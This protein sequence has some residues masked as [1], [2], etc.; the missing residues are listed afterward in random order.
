MIGLLA[1]SLTLGLRHGIDWD[2]I[3]AIAD[4]TSTAE[5]RRRGW[6][7]SLF[8]ALG[9]AAVVFLLGVLVIAFSTTL[10][11][12]T[13]EWLGRV[14]GFTLVAL[15]VWVL[16]ELGRKGEDFRLRSRWMLVLSGTFAGLRRVRTARSGRTIGVDHQHDHDHPKDDAASHTATHAHD[17]SHLD[18]EAP[19][20]VVE[21]VGSGMTL[22]PA[23]GQRRRWFDAGHSP[24]SSH[25]H[26][27]H[28]AIALPDDP[29]SRYEGRTAAGIGMLHGVGIESPTQIALFVVASRIGGLTNGLLLLAAWCVGLVVANIG[30]A[31]LAGLGLLSA[32]R[33]FR[34]YAF[35]AILVAVG[36]I[37]MGLAMIGGFEFL[38][39]LNV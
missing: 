5:T 36:S 13:A 26:R 10:P 9:H 25:A 11:E 4:L 18:V 15:G 20:D 24:T 37:A 21:P 29:F 22:N 7:L 39:E 28:H 34:L 8:Y 16:I 14:V 33:N 17:H 2:H 6:L 32:E 3:A 19:V 30:I 31:T 35:V 1:T 38:P 23:N 27:H 12:G